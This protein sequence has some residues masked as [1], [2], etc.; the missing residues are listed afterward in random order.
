M[1]D[2]L[3]RGLKVTMGSAPPVLV[4]G[5]SILGEGV[6]P[7]P[8]QASWVGVRFPNTQLTKLKTEARYSGA[9]E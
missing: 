5:P 8:T 6:S 7:V 4:N 2:E 1:R 9:A 3:A